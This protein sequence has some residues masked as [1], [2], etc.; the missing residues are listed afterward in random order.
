M[1]KKAEI[2]KL[3]N[4]YRKVKEMKEIMIYFLETTNIKFKNKTKRI[5]KYKK[6]IID[7]KKH[8][9]FV[10]KFDGFKFDVE[11][12]NCEKFLEE[13]IYGLD[14]LD[15]MKLIENIEK[16]I[17][18]LNEKNKKITS[19]FIELN[20]YVFINILNDVALDSYQ[21][22]LSNNIRELL[23]NLHKNAKNRK[24][25]IIVEQK[26]HD[27]EANISF[28]KKKLNETK[29]VHD[30]ILDYEQKI[31]DILQNLSILQ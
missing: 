31:Y 10:T 15:L 8:V 6:E 21:L 22:L 26:I 23:T 20:H 12:I 3:I 17:P 18:I 2:Y 25:E 14:F 27:C 4:N 24:D 11:T 30:T 9:D 7:M 1:E 5:K 28:Y 29:K 16:T 13:Q 19:D